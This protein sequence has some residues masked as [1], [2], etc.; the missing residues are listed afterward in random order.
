MNKWVL[1]ILIEV[2]PCIVVHFGGEIDMHPS[3]ARVR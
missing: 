2:R 1:V 3:L